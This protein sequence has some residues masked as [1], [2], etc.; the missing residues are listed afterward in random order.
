MSQACHVAPSLVPN[1]STGLTAAIAQRG[2]IGT[3]VPEQQQAV[4]RNEVRQSSE[5]QPHRVEVL[6]DVG[7]IELDVADDGNLRQVL[8]ELGGLVEERA[9]VFVALDHELLAAPCPIA[10]TA[11]SQVQRDAA[12]EHRRVAVARASEASRS[13]PLWSFCRACRR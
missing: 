10:G 12:D 3:V 9:V 4:P 11:V 6:I 13:A 8:Q 5:R 1:V 2:R 7:V